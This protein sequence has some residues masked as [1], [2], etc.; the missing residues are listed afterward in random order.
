MP[1]LKWE[2]NIQIKFSISMMREC[3]SETSVSGSG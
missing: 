2:D 1:R 3:E